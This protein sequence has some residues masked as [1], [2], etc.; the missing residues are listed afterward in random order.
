[1]ALRSFCSNDFKKLNISS[2]PEIMESCSKNIVYLDHL[3]IKT[4]KLDVVGEFQFGIFYVAYLWLFSFGSIIDFE[5]VHCY[6]SYSLRKKCLYSEFF[7][8]AFGLNTERY[9]ISLCIHSEWGKIWTK[10]S[11]NTDTF[12]AVVITTINIASWRNKSW[13]L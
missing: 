3:E 4:G 11:P 5:Y 9:K 13:M 12:H 6:S 7:F 1:M 8:P 10:K 2:I